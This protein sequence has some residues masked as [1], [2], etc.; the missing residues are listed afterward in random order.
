MTFGPKRSVLDISY[1]SAVAGKGDLPAKAFPST[2]AQPAV[3]EGSHPSHS[4][5]TSGRSRPKVGLAQFKLTDLQP[6]ELA[7]NSP[8]RITEKIDG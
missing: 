3:A 5:L 6:W 4:Q 7:G 2:H 1:R 8:C